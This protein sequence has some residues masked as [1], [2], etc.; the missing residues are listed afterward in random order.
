MRTLL[1]LSFAL[2]LMVA[3]PAGAETI[4]A[5]W[6]LEQC[7]LNTTFPMGGN[8]GVSTRAQT[9]AFSGGTTSFGTLKVEFGD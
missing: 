9:F 4:S 8:V 2:A 6:Y 7:C 3:L 1:L 5:E